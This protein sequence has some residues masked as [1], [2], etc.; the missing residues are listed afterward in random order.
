[1]KSRLRRLQCDSAC[2]QGSPLRLAQP[3]L[4]RERRRHSR[5][6]RQP[7]LPRRRSSAGARSARLSMGGLSAH[8]ERN[9]CDH[10]ALVVISLAS[11]GRLR[12]G[13]AWLLP[14]TRQPP[15]AARNSRRRAAGAAGSMSQ[16]QGHRGPCSEVRQV[17]WRWPRTPPAVGST[18]PLAGCCYASVS[19]LTSEP[20]AGPGSPR[21]ASAPPVLGGAPATQLPWWRISLETTQG[22]AGPEPA[23]RGAVWLRTP[24]G[25][26]PRRSAVSRGSLSR[27]LVEALRPRT[28]ASCWQRGRLR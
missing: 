10:F 18:R 13:G 5:P 12:R 4:P 16:A 11:L 6:R 1:M 9:A 7:K 15:C 17:S 27:G 25:D 3:M 22:V 20:P 21:V 19:R 24:G 2:L 28:R 26:E 8:M 23:Q 14:A